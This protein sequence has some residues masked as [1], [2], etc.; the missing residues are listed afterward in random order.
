MKRYV[1]IGMAI[2]SMVLVSM[3][4]EA[5]VAVAQG[6]NVYGSAQMHAAFIDEGTRT[7]V[8]DTGIKAVADY[9][10]S[11]AGVKALIKGTCN[12]AAVARKLKMLEKSQDKSMVETLVARDA[13]AVYVDKGN[14]INELSLS[15]LQKVFSGRVTD[16]K[17]VGGASGP[18]Q[19]VIPQTKT[20]CN[21]N[22]CKMAMGNAGFAKSSVI[23]Q[24]ADGTLENVNGN[25]RAVSFISYGAIATRPEF[26]ALKVDGK[27]PNDA[28]YP[29]IQ[30]LY[31]VTKGR[32]SGD[33][34]AYL[35]YFLTGNGK[36]IIQKNGMF[37]AQ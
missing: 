22:F 14:P 36:A 28:G 35:D 5:P 17:D 4:G 15:D 13:I 20:A 2:V 29:I 30:E 23:T 33:L 6:I 11:G 1:L 21:K 19:V 31:L 3:I 24:R 27:A 32:P 34:K 25:S 7:F 26:K 18:I 12:I 10:T 8:K 16:W 9:K 37:P